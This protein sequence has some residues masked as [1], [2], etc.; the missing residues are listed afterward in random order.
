M[1][2]NV[3]DIVFKSTK[4]LS[5]TW[6]VPCSCHLT[7]LQ[8]LFTIEEILLQ[9]NLVGNAFSLPQ[10][11]KSEKMIVGLLGF[12]HRCKCG[13]VHKIEMNLCGL[14]ILNLHFPESSAYILSPKK[15]IILWIWIFFPYAL[16][17]MLSQGI[18]ETLI[19]HWYSPF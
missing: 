17:S 12:C 9:C 10:I 6:L 7:C 8:V 2:I 19:F 14:K 15:I 13:R 1:T 3:N 18:I 16:S 4:K 11:K 5:S